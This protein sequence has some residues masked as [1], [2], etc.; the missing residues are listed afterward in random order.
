MGVDCG[1][2]TATILDADCAETS[3]RHAKKVDNG[4]AYAVGPTAMH[5]PAWCCVA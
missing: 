1:V 3:L 2:N 4:D 5:A